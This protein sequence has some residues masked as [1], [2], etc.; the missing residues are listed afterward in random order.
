MTFYNSADD[1]KA[2]AGQCETRLRLKSVPRQFFRG[3][4]RDTC[5]FADLQ[6]CGFSHSFNYE[7]YVVVYFV[8]K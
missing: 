2:T 7:S 1:A 8:S 6:R 4:P 5:S 3:E